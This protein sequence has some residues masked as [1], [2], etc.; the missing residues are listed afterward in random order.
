[1]TPT[2]R[3]P[4]RRC[5]SGS[6]RR[7]TA[8]ALLFAGLGSPSE[9]ATEAVLIWFPAKEPVA[10]I[11]TLALAPLASAPRLQ[12]TVVVPAHVPWLGVAETHVSPGG[13]VSVR[14][15]FV[16]FARAPRWRPSG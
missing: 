9:A 1:M 2:S 6:S 15:T 5:G 12:V 14:V 16:A 3:R 10:T 11:A 4:G 8:L 7:P 13:S